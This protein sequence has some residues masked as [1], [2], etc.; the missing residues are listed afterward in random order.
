MNPENALYLEH[1]LCAFL[2]RILIDVRIVLKRMASYAMIGLHTANFA[3][4][5]SF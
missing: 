2:S 4:I 5:Q 3:C 1:M